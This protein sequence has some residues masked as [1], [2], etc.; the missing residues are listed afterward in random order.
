M[1]IA[2][3]S[4][5][6]SES[7]SKLLRNRWAWRLYALLRRSIVSRTTLAILVPSMLLGLT[8]ASVVSW[9][10]D[11]REQQRA[12]IRLQQLLS[13]VERTAQIACYLNDRTLAAEIAQGLM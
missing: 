13:T 6:V 9:T 8:F 3:R 5:I 4:T 12:E 2:P 1:W 7:R 10:V 11:R